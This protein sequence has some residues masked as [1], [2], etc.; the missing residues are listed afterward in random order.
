M[1]SSIF[2]AFYLAYRTYT[3]IFII[4]ESA[5]LFLYKF[6][7]NSNLAQKEKKKS[8]CAKA[9]GPITPGPGRPVCFPRHVR[10]LLLSRGH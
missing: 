8:H 2:P 5:Q 1:E 9:A 6:K 3:K 4:F 10:V 7:H